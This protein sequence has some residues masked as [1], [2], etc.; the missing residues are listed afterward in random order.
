VIHGEEGARGSSSTQQGSQSKA[1]LDGLQYGKKGAM[2]LGIIQF[3]VV[4]C[5]VLGE[6]RTPFFYAKK[7]MFLSRLKSIIYCMVPVV[8]LS[9]G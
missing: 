2:W 4:T 7:F 5:Q 3:R 9:D 8:N 6:M 1:G